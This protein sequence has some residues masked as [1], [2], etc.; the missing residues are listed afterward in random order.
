MKL[1]IGSSNPHGR[2]RHS[3]WVCLDL[4]KETKPHVVG[5]A[6]EMPFA[7]NTFDEV[8]AVHVLEHLQRDHWPL[9]LAEIFRVLQEGGHFYVEVPDFTEQCRMFIK[10]ME[11]PK[12]DREAIHEIRTAIWGKTERLGMGHQFGFDERF[13]ANA[14]AKSG[15]DDIKLLD[16][17]EDMISHHFRFGPVLLYESTKSEHRPRVN[18]REMDF[19]TLREYIIK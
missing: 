5:D 2:Y 12:P 16:Q 19:N 7:D 18:V 14:L 8:H 15:F 3:G 4:N 6:F 10:A 13:L 9:M 1:N 17:R 11:A